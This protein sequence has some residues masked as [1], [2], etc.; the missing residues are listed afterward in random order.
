MCSN[1]RFVLHLT[2][3]ALFVVFIALI[4]TEFASAVLD[5][6]NISTASAPVHIPTRKRGRPPGRRKVELS[7]FTD[8]EAPSAAPS[9]APSE[10]PVEESIDLNG[11]A[12]PAKRVRKPP[13]RRKA[14]VEPTGIA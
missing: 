12:P 7:L 2:T 14:A 8:S 5:D 1:K 4:G 9:E 13:V 6:D 11:P 3:I 10:A